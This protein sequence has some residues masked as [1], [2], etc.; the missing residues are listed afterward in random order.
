MWLPAETKKMICFES[1][2]APFQRA[3][4]ATS[5]VTN[6]TWGGGGVEKR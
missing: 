6:A 5:E 1:T 2:V 3:L 4:N